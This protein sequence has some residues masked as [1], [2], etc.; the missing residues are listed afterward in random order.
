MTKTKD[1]ERWTLNDEHWT[2]NVEH[3][4]MNIYYNNYF[5]NYE[6]ES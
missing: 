2:M 6:Q 4:T 5:T 3:W 1:V